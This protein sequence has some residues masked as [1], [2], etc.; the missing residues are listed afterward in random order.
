[1]NRQVGAKVLP[2]VSKCPDRPLE[3]VI[4]ISHGVNL[5][6]DGNASIA[7]WKIGGEIACGGVLCED[8][9]AGG[10]IRGL[11]VVVVVVVVDVVVA[12]SAK[13]SVAA[14]PL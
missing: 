5:E 12:G 1:M 13:S 6:L 14:N 7:P 3:S 9:P 4:T 8:E 2:R 11:V 10:A